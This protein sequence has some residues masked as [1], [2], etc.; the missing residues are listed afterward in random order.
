[1]G[2]SLKNGKIVG[3]TKSGKNASFPQENVDILI[4][5]CKK[6]G[7]STNYLIAAVLA[8]VAKESLFVPKNEN[9]NY[10]E[11]GLLSIFPSK[12]GPGRANANEYSK[13]PE[14]I[15]NWV[16]D[17]SRNKTHDQPG[18]GWK[19][20]GRGFNQITFKD[21][22]KKFGKMV[23]QDLVNNPDKLNEVQ[24]AADVCVAFYVDG[25]NSYKRKIKTKFGQDPLDIQDYDKAL[26]LIINL[27]AGFGFSTQ[28]SVV[29]YNYE[30]AKEYH[31]FLIEY[32]EQKP[33]DKNPPKEK[34]IDN[35]PIES[36]VKSDDQVL[37]S[38]EAMGTPTPKYTES[39]IPVSLKQ[40][41]KPT[42]KPTEI[43]FPDIGKY[44]NKKDKMVHSKGITSGP[45][46]YYNGTQISPE[47]ILSLILFQEGILPTISLIYRDSM[48]IFRDFGFPVDDTIITI[49]INSRSQFLRSIY[50][51]FKISNFKDLG[52][53]NYKIDGICNIPQIFLR[54]FKSYSKKTSYEA[55]QQI[56]KDCQLGFCSNLDNSKDKMTWINPGL[57]T[58]EFINEIV[59]NSYHSDSSFLSVYIDYYYNICYVELEKELGRDISEDKML[60]AV[61]ASE[62]T[63]SNDVDEQVT[64][65][66]LTVNQSARNSNAFIENYKVDNRSTQISLR[67]SYLMKTKYYDSNK[68]ELLIFDVDSIS[69]SGSKTIVMKANPSDANYY[70]ENISNIWLGK[71]DRF[72]DD[73]SGNAHLNY[74]YSYIQNTQNL[75]D[76][77]KISATFKLPTVNYNLYK[78]QKVYINFLDDRKRSL[79]ST[80]PTHKRL[81]GDWLIVN[82]DLKY[83]NNSLYQEVVAIK[84]ELSMDD[85]EIEEN[86]SSIQP[87]SD[88]SS[89]TGNNENNENN[90]VPNEDVGQ[91]AQGIQDV[92]VNTSQVED[93][94]IPTSDLDYILEHSMKDNSGVIRKLISIKGKAVDELVGIAFLKMQAAAKK[95]KIELSINSG[96]RPAFGKNYVGKTSKGNNISVTTQESLRRDKSNWVMSERAKYKS[97]DDF[98]FNA[99]STAYKPYTAKPGSSNHGNGIALDLN[100]GSRISFNKILKD[101]VYSWLIKNGWRYGFVR[102]VGTEEWH[103]EYQPDK[104]K[105]GPYAVVKNV[106]GSSGD[107]LYYDDL[108]LNNISN[109]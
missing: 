20:R 60:T 98:V 28:S 21:A 52:D 22:Y 65:L 87:S 86:K 88:S 23:G 10:S 5:S 40:W 30:H 49:Y 107:N 18:D 39:F 4:E 9:L 106:G 85:K 14:K 63:G 105:K 79:T 64:S 25:F 73:G 31:S 12:F 102:A 11:S 96:F 13:K 91:E 66:I 82:I 77:V 54:K 57:T 7:L 56:A 1:M 101:K 24:D 58:H 35:Q 90:L 109:V 74:N 6:G 68:K 44:Y 43:S 104:A 33:E 93:I 70:K 59:M 75:D 80:S 72:D 78:F 26:L 29:Q 81:E 27:T 48:G 2:Y 99:P 42:I 55:L 41:S 84:R 92:T 71:L 19:Y 34:S 46:V 100:V 89:N 50:M 69:T 36:D 47:D 83:E 51:D 94:P 17:S 103:F 32:L 62:L 67:K 8:T 3:K 37:E 38:D 95:D 53:G 97:D 61:G 45:V 15:A 76:L 108:G 16:Y